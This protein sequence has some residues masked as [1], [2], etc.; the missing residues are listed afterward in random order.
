MFPSSKFIYLSCVL[1]DRQGKYTE[2]VVAMAK[3]KYRRQYS[4]YMY[5]PER[6]EKGEKVI[7]LVLRQLF[8]LNWCGNLF[9]KVE[10]LNFSPRERDRKES[11]N[12]YL[13]FFNVT[14]WLLGGM[15]VALLWRCGCVGFV[16][17]LAA[18]FLVGLALSVLLLSLRG[19]FTL[20]SYLSI[21]RN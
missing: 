2:I 11:S 9:R 1:W 12:N 3:V 6:K 7:E 14:T 8:P 20:L 10:A 5:K 17:V 21:F 16:V 18:H 4:A 15:V 19:G 13:I